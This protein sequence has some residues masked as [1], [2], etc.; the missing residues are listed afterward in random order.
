MIVVMQQ[1]AEEAAT[2]RV[3]RHVEA[4][5]LGAYVFHGE[6]RNV[7]AVLDPAAGPGLTADNPDL[8]GELET[9]AGVERVDWTT[10][11]FKL[12]GRDVRPAGTAFGLGEARIGGDFAVIAGSS[13]PRP[14]QELA[15]L[16]RA[17]REAGARVFW[18]GRGDSGDFRRDLLAALDEL[19]IETGLPAVVDVWEPVEVD[20]LSRHADALLVP[21]QQM[22]NFPLIK[23]VGRGDRP[24]VLCRGPSAT[25]EEWLMVAE[26]ALQAGNMRVALCEQ[27][28]R[29]FEP[30]VRATLDFS[31]IAVA[32]R[33]SHLP[34]LANPSLP[35]G[36]YD[37]VP[38]LSLAATAAGA[39]GLL[40]DVHLGAAEDA[41]A[42]PQSLPIAELAALIPRLQAARDVLGRRTA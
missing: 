16:G 35:A 11:P 1:R 42:G 3:V 17:A 24:V 26:R 14:A 29:T 23:E 7:I 32:K 13:R 12:A 20:R 6:E 4:A 37:L 10:R 36:H 40:I 15:A 5:G 19:R 39:D 30:S 8:R 27:G 34:L 31:G 22:Q 25:V 33:L 9:L 41:S 18:V 2:A 21:A 38:E 28:I